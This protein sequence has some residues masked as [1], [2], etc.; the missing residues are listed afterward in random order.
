MPLKF[1]SLPPN[2][3][4]IEDECQY[5]LPKC[6]WTIT[7][8]DETL[9]IVVTSKK[10]T[11]NYDFW[12]RVTAHPEGNPNNSKQTEIPKHN[13]LLESLSEA[14]NEYEVFFEPHLN[15]H[16]LHVLGELLFFLF[17]EDIIPTMANTHLAYPDLAIDKIFGTDPDQDVESFIQFIERK[18]NFPLGGA[19]GDAGELANYTF[20]KKSLFSFL[21]RVPAAEWYK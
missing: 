6:P 10:H 4:D 7:F 20:R 17:W 19:P 15:S 12:R 9:K 3:D 8:D 1:E 16:Q 18:I 21:V 2:W 13:P 14:P 5:N 11:F